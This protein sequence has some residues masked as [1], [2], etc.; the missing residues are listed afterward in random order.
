MKLLKESIYNEKEYQYNTLEYTIDD[1]VIVV[2][3]IDDKT[4]YTVGIIDMI[5]I[6]RDGI[7]YS[8]EGSTCQVSKR[9][10]FPY[11]TKKENELLN[12]GYSYIAPYQVL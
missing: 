10:I 2:Q 9:D 8:I 7:Q 11:S 6:T 4:C 3:H 5:T 12:K 1:E